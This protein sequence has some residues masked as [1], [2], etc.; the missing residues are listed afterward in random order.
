MKIEKALEMKLFGPGKAHP[1]AKGCLGD[2]LVLSKK[3]K[4]LKQCLPNDLYEELLAYHSS[5]TK[6]EMILPLI[7]LEKK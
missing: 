4:N 1:L 2:Y 3:N 6:K 5:L 7:I